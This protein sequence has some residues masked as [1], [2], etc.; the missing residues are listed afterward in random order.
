MTRHD[1]DPD[2]DRLLERDPREIWSESS[3]MDALFAS[4][5]HWVGRYF[6]AHYLT[7]PNPGSYLLPDLRPALQHRASGAHEASKAGCNVVI[8][9]GSPDS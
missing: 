3:V 5:F 2:P 8:A 6:Q 1:T 9:T 7:M 4:G